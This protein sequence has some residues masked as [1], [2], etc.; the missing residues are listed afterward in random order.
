MKFTTVSLLCTLLDGYPVDMQRQ[1][2]LLTSD[3]L[4]NC[5]L[6]EKEKNHARCLDFQDL[7]FHRNHSFYFDIDRSWYFLFFEYNLMINMQSPFNFLYKFHICLFQIH[8][9]CCVACFVQFQN[10]YNFL[11]TC[12]SLCYE[13]KV[14]ANGIKIWTVCT[15]IKTVKLM[16]W[17]CLIHY[18]YCI[19][20][21]RNLKVKSKVLSSD[22]DF[23]IVVERFQ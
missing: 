5:F 19:G 23:P 8:I 17:R 15:F 21:Q 20:T 10:I 22:I 2:N 18:N 4:I 12:N 1:I 7:A 6:E 16:S 13:I 9:H 14:S 11:S 3:Y